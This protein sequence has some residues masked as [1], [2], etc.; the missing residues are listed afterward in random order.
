MLEDFDRI[1]YLVETF[2]KDALVV[3]GSRKLPFSSEESMIT[4]GP[5][6]KGRKLTKGE[7]WNLYHDLSLPLRKELGV[8]GDANILESVFSDFVGD[9]LNIKEEGAKVIKTEES[10]CDND[11]V[12]QSIKAEQTVGQADND[13]HQVAPGDDMMKDDVAS[14]FNV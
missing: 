8:P 13:N 9:E 7:V 6:N 1:H 3:D 5:P 14:Y 4:V 11:N 10:A 2:K 12:G